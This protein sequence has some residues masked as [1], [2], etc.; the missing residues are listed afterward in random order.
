MADELELFQTDLL[1]SVR[2]M[3]P[4]K[5]ARVTRVPLS[6]ATEELRKAGVSQSVFA[7]LSSVVTR[8]KYG[9]KK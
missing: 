7:N 9:G 8:A 6:S 2:Q 1:E 3:K 4:G 5:A